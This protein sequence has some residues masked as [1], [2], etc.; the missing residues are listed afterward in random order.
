M[1]TESPPNST[2]QPPAFPGL[3]G[4]DPWNAAWRREGIAE[5][6]VA[7]LRENLGAVRLVD[8]RE[9]HEWEGELG[10][11]E[12]AELVPLKTLGDA[13]RDWDRDAP[14][15]IICRSGRRSL[16]AAGQLEAMGFARVAS[17]AGGMID[18]RR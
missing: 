7:W 15:A 3:D 14:L 16:R 10:H 13:A 18:W 4:G 8:V 11:V 5:V 2:D 9:L 6:S 17:V 1:S 12:A